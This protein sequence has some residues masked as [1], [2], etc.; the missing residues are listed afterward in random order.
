MGTVYHAIQE[1]LGRRVAVKLL[2]PRLAEDRDQLERF[3]REAEVVA[4]LGHPNIVQVTDFHYPDAES[5]QP[6][7]VMELL[8]GESFGACI[9]RLGVLPFGRVAFIVAQVLS[10]L[11]AAHRAGVV[12]RDIKPDNV[13]LLSDAA[14][15]DT[16]KVLDF[17][18]AKMS[19][20]G[21]A[22]LT[23]TGAMLGTPAF[24]APEQARGA[25]DV[26]ARADI[27][28]V[29]AM[30]YQALTGKLPYEAPSVPALLFA[31]VEKSPASLRVARP[32]APDELVAIVERAMAKDRNARFAD[33]EEMRRALAP[34]SGLP[35]S[36]PPPVSATAATMVGASS[37]LGA[38][39]IVVHRTP[40]P[41]AA[42]TKPAPEPPKRSF[43]AM[44]MITLVAIV[45]VLTVGAVFIVAILAKSRE[46]SA[47][48]EDPV[49]ASG[50]AFAQTIAQQAIASSSAN[51]STVTQ[52][53]PPPPAA[54]T[55]AVTTAVPAAPVQHRYSSSKG[56]L[57]GSDFGDC[58]KCDW[59]AFRAD[60]S[61]KVAEISA[62]F[63]ASIHEPPKHEIMYYKVGVTASGDYTTFE[64][65][66]DT[67]LPPRL[68]R[69]LTDVI[70]RTPLHKAGGKAGSFKFGFSSECPKWA[71][72]D[73]LKWCP[74]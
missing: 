61:A 35:A 69:C 1:G 39:P 22:K 5:P 3:R 50:V 25:V 9:A 73:T 28:A 32:D 12:H 20:D 68:D 45:S 47:R 65:Q 18:I 70:K 63:A 29:G 43:D 8:R 66:G 51:A 67:V 7:L 74:D 14:V 57:S 52:A 42:P 15:P 17:G 4:A 16:V 55:I 38:T 53:P 37:P 23:G 30:M 11:S 27:Y 46:P 34:W 49:T 62:C 24:M 10:A 36:I 71:P 59:E 19:V 41:E 56:S 54:S 72:P 44:K 2:D 60:M 31:I 13:F 48:H 64:L 26:D 6:F 58:E 21:Q 40:P 33:A